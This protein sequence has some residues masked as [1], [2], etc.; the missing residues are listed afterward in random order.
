MKVG[1]GVGGGGGEDGW[2][3]NRVGKRIRIR[4]FMA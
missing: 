3:A 1:V 2:G 4:N